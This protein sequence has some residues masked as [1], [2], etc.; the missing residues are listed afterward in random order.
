MADHIHAGDAP[1]FAG[2]YL[3]AGERPAAGAFVHDGNPPG[4]VDAYL[5]AGERPAVSGAVGSFVY[6][7]DSPDHA[8]S[9]LY[10]PGGLGLR[11]AL[12]P[13]TGSGGRG[14]LLANDVAASGWAEVEVRVYIQSSS[15][16]SLKV[17][18][19]SSWQ[20]DSLTSGSFTAVQRV[21]ADGVDQG[22]TTLQVTIP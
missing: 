15:F 20:A 21:Y 6:G 10:S 14:G 3:Y 17:F 19:D 12:V 16:A 5:Y 11:G 8:G 2:S 22:T 7:G 18:N 9:Y 13:T 1:G 4:V